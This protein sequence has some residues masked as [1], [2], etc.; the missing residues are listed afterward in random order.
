M[1]FISQFG[2]HA[3][4]TLGLEGLPWWKHKAAPGVGLGAHCES[5]PKGLLGYLGE[6]LEDL[7]RWFSKKPL[8]LLSVV[9]INGIS[10]VGRQHG[11]NVAVIILDLSPSFFSQIDRV[12]LWPFVSHGASRFLAFR[13]ARSF[14][15]G[16]H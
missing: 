9:P 2:R 5:E 11:T 10:K 3:T 14:I 4:P 12:D 13:G 7:G 8:P 15:I 6:D 16:G 1:R